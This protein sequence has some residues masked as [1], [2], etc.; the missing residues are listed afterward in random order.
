MGYVSSWNLNKRI[1]TLGKLTNRRNAFQDMFE[2]NRIIFSLLE[3]K[4]W[5]FQAL[6]QPNSVSICK[7]YPAIPNDLDTKNNWSF[8]RKKKD[9]STEDPKNEPDF[10]LRM[11]TFDHFWPSSISLT[12]LAP[13]SC[14]FL[15]S[16]TFWS[17]YHYPKMERLQMPYV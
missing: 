13:N 5:W 7:K 12:N 17:L 11:A 15:H 4:T 8:C 10:E 9:I 6:G 3:E 1:F 16:F 2:I 14:S